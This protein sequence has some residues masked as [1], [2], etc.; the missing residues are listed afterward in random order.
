VSLSG[1]GTQGTYSWTSTYGQPVT[2]AATVT[3]QDGST[4][5]GT[6]AFY[7]AEQNNGSSS[8]S[9]DA[10]AADLV[11]TVPLKT[12]GGV[13]KATLTYNP[14]PGQYALLAVYSGDA[15]HLADIAGAGGS[16]NYFKTQVVDAQTTAVTV[17]SSAT[18]SVFG[19]AVTF[20]A[21]VTSGRTGPDGRTGVVTF[22]NAGV[23][24][25]TAPVATKSGVTTARL[26]TADLPV[27]S[28]SITA[29][30]SGDYNY[31]GTTS[32]ALA[33]TV[34]APSPPT[35]VTVTGKSTVTAG[36]V[37]T[38]T[39]ATNGTGAVRFSLA[40][41]PSHP[42]KMTIAASTGKITFK[43]PKKGLKSFSYAVVA[44]NAAGEVASR[45][46]KVKVS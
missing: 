31:V 22:Y 37:Y 34:H 14:P 18:S 17:K 15:T 39:T 27:G 42:A 10:T 35:K 26:A 4:P 25:G 44:S 9:E 28:D 32:A 41:N 7:A 38:A 8:S 1:S 24:F 23:P 3:A 36:S 20:T 40:S 13:T 12:A 46:I 33:Q 6:V 16:T 21:T 11:G 43:V 5:T 29:I 19:S 2:L 30:Y 45:V